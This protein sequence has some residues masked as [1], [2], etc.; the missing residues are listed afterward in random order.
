M[1]TAAMLG[2]ETCYNCDLPHVINVN[3]QERFNPEK[4][5]TKNLAAAAL[6]DISGAWW[7]EVQI[8]GDKSSFI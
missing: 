7:R 4:I 5:E 8:Y 2:G 3:E 6:P 1:C